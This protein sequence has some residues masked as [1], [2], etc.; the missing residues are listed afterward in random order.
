MADVTS[1]QT[2]RDTTAVP[3]A[4]TVAAVTSIGDD[5]RQLMALR[6]RSSLRDR[7]FA[8]LFSLLDPS[9]LNGRDRRYAAL[10]SLL[11]EGISAMA[12]TA[13]REAAR[14]LLGSGPGRWRTVSQ[15][16]G[17][18]AAVFNCGWDA[19]RRRRT[20]GTSQL[21]DTL[22]AL[23]EALATRPTA[24]GP[25]PVATPTAPPE[26]PGSPQGAWAKTATEPRITIEGGPTDL[27]LV[28]PLAP[29]R[30]NPPGQPPPDGVQRRLVLVAAAGALALALATTVL[31]LSLR[32]GSTPVAKAGEA[33]RNVACAVLT[34]KPGDLP[35]AADA[36]LRRWAPTFTALA[37]TLPESE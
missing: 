27:A 13:H 11:D 2:A 1:H 5:L 18:A 28:A 26:S 37:A 17:E 20:N 31:V 25:V 29:T 15:R 12:D 3:H 22:E 32:S 9:E 35:A 14:A 36:E 6:S 7:H 34:D 21:D 10:T 30:S 24:I 8:N 4:P 23:A 19:Y 33:N 16:G